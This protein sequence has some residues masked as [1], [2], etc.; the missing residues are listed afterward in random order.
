[1]PTLAARLAPDITT[2]GL[3]VKCSSAAVCPAV[4]R[5]LR[6]VDARAWAVSSARDNM[7]L[8]FGGSVVSVTRD[9]FIAFVFLA[10][11]AGL[12]AG[13]ATAGETA[14]TYGLLRAIGAGKSLALGTGMVQA[15][16]MT[17]PA[18]LFAW[19]SGVPLSHL[20]VSSAS[21]AIG[22][23]SGSSISLWSA[24]SAALLVAL[25]ACAGVGV[26][27]GLAASRA[28]ARSLAARL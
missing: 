11:L 1:L 3:F 16:A 13:L 8:P 14:S 20:V 23:L 4:G 22:G 2:N 21:A 18:A 25:V 17:F 5:R 6:A 24:G 12:Y 9:L 28:P 10:A 26:P 27:L 19:V 15:A 7:A